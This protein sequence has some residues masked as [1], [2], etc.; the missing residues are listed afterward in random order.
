MTN[1]I[2]KDG[3]HAMTRTGDGGRTIY[4]YV[5]NVDPI[6][7]SV[8]NFFNAQPPISVKVSAE[9]DPDWSAVQ[10]VLDAIKR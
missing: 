4:Y 8:I 5:A 6:R 10:E 1:I 7:N 2:G 3:L 9:P